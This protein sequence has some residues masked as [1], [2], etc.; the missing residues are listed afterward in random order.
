L[1]F[2]CCLAGALAVLSLGAEARHLRLELLEIQNRTREELTAS[3]LQHEAVVQDERKAALAEA[4]NQRSAL[5]AELN[6][7]ALI[8]GALARQQ[9]EAEWASRLAHDPK[10]AK[11]AMERTLV[12][13]EKTGRD[14]QTSAQSALEEV[15]R[16]AAPPRSR[17][18]VL[19]SGDGF[20]VKV[21]FRMSALTAN[22]TG[23]VTKHHDTESM[24]REIQDLSARVMIALCDYC[25]SRGIESLSVSCNHAIHQTLIPTGASSAERDALLARASVVMGR[26]YRVS[27]DRQR[28]SSVSNWRRIA[29]SKVIAMMLVE[30]DNLNTLQ[31]SGTAF[32]PQTE[33]DGELEF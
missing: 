21:A 11:S 17:V 13:M 6:D 23:A 18:Q 29:P 27:L 24:R 15:A 10:I 12:K 16:L 30:N 20:S 22:E 32:S 14:P 25:G 19:P 2:A 31:I 5:E 4:E 28:V 8:S 33:P 1:V 7:P 3:R 9:H 26:L